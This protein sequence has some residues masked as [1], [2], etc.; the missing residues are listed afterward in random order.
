[1][2]G[3]L[4]ALGSLTLT[5]KVGMLTVWSKPFVPLSREKLGARDSLPIVRCCAKGAIYGMRV[6]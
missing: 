5:L 3:E 2:N 1:M 4:G 6:S